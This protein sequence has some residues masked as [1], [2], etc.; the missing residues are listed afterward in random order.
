VFEFHP[1]VFPEPEKT[2][3]ELRDMN[4]RI[5]LHIT[6]CYSGLHGKIDDENVSPLEYDHV[7][8]YWKKHEKLYNTAK[9]ECWWPDDADEVD[10]RARLARWRM[11]YEGCLK[12]NPDTRPFQMQR[13]TFPG[14]NKWG[15][16]IWT[17]DVDS[18]W[19][20]LKNQVPIGLNAALSSSPYW[21]TDTGGFY[22][23]KEFDGELFIRWFQYSTFTPFIRGH[24]R[25]SFLR[26]LWGWTMFNSLDEIPLEMTEKYHDTKPLDNILPDSR[27]L[28]LCKAMLNARYEL[29]PYIYNLS[30]EV[31][32]GVPM[33]RPM[34]YK[35][36]GDET[37]SGLGDQYMFG[38]G[39]RGAPI[40][41]KGAAK[42]SD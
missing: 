40:T 14:A 4:Y 22:S 24:G 41:E 37:A 17:G 21:G 32:S 12:L 36:H 25:S 2:M 29:L 27:V 23:D 15:G 20:T 42:R 13:N 28:P 30:H 26:K 18:Q 11:Y 8:N 39:L 35:Y 16:I 34:W 33:L 5:N 19:E 9:N 3:R 10:M 38:D 7:K 31:L 6:K 1:D